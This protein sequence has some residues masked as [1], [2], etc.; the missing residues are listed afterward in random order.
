MGYIALIGDIMGSRALANRAECQG[1]LQSICSHL[2]ENRD[3]YGMASPL[4]LT[5]GDEFQALFDSPRGIWQCI[6]ALESTMYPVNIR[7]AL[8]VGGIVTGIN[9]EAALA[10]DGP[11]F[12]RA[13]D[14]M[15]RLKKE[16]GRYYRVAGPLRCRSLP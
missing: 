4:T 6:A 12:H 3:H 5:L 13:R 1:R 16:K 15:D 2:N 7:F 10:M 8:G 14:A 11:A 9:R